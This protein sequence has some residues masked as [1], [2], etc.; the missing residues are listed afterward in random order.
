MYQGR[1]KILTPT[2]TCSARRKIEQMKRKKA[3]WNLRKKKLSF[4]AGTGRDVMTL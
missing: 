4:A 1:I 3:A 2:M